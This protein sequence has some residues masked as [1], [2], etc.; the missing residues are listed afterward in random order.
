M[1]GCAA[2]SANRVTY[3]KYTMVSSWYIILHMYECLNGIPI[4]NHIGGTSL[5]PVNM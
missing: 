4:G 3:L 1:N 2:I 5:F